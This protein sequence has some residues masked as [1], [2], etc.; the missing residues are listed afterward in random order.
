MARII[1]TET[2]E[3]TYEIDDNSDLFEPWRN[4]EVGVDEFHAFLS[5]GNPLSESV[6]ERDIEEDY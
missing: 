6:T 4:G 2:I 3:T 1:V 5:Q